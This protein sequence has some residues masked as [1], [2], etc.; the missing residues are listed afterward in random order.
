MLLAIK[1]NGFRLQTLCVYNGLTMSGLRVLSAMI[2]DREIGKNIDDFL[3]LSLRHPV[4][5]EHTAYQ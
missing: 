4:W 1:V 2:H 3:Y 5:P